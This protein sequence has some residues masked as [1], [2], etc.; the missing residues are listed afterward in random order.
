MAETSSSNVDGSTQTSRLVPLHILWPFILL[1]SC[2]MWWGIANNMTDP[3]VKA[4]RGIFKDLSNF[5][6]SLIQFAFYGAYFSLAIPGA[7]IARKFSYKIGV[8]VG[9]GLYCLG[10]FLLFPASLIQQFVPFLIAYYVLASGLSILETN[11]NPYLLSLGP[12]KTSTQRLNLAQSFN[13]VGS[14]IGT[15]LCQLLILARLEELKESTVGATVEQ[16]GEIQSQQ[17]S[18]VITP[19]LIVGGV[20]IAVWLLIALKKMPY[21]RESDKNLHFI[22][23]FG[24][25]FRN[26]NYLFAVIAQFFY[27]GAQ[28]CVWTFTVYYI[29]AQLGIKDSDALKY[30]TAALVLFGVCRFICTALMSVIKPHNLL[31]AL[32]VLGGILTCIVI[33]VGGKIGVYSL[34][35]ISGCM[36]LMFPTIFGLGSRGLGRDRKIA[37]SGLIMAILGAAILVPL[38]AFIID[39]VNVNPHG[40]DPTALSI[41]ASYSIPLICFIV[42]AAYGIFAGKVKIK[43][44]TEA[45]AY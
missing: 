11:A 35:G 36:S 27:V 33:F 34:V 21:V 14:I 19:Y 8:L 1:A 38:Q 13:P 10:C 40:T 4:F 18:I 15:L 31:A 30:H 12:E 43:E 42:V 23:T 29:P 44:S 32:S 3:L 9:L 7:I 5:Q 39:K 2:F 28:L 6:S 24:R 45:E 41:S 25:L 17:L 26:A 22:E 20:L 16:M 37:G